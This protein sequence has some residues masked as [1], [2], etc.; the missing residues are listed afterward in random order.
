MAKVKEDLGLKMGS[1]KE[2]IWTK[3]KKEAEILI[4]Q[5][6]ENLIIQKELLNLAKTKIAEEKEN[7]K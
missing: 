5:S 6:E 7:F 4:E 2:V 1:R 3:I